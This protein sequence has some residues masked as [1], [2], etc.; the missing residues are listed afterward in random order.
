MERLFPAVSAVIH[1][2]LH[3]LLGHDPVA[4]LLGNGKE[5]QTFLKG[6]LKTKEL[7]R[8]REERLPSFSSSMV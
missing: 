7:K 6:S 1:R 3:H 2:E 5:R 4:Q 8:L